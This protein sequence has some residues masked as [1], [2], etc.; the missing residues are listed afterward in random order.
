MEVRAAASGYLGSD[1]VLDVDLWFAGEDFSYFAAARP[2]VFYRLGT[3][4]A[5][6]GIVHGLH[7]PRFTVDED[8]LRTGAGCMAYLAWNWLSKAAG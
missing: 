7:T 5:A 6:R 4:N 8:A 2:G 1:R 3:G